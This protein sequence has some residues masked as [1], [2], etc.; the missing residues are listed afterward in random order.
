MA[1]DPVKVSAQGQTAE[2]KVVNDN[3]PAS[4]GT[5]PADQTQD[6]QPITNEQKANLD[7]STSGQTSQALGQIQDPVESN[8]QNNNQ[9]KSKSESDFADNTTVDK[10]TSVVGQH[11]SGNTNTL[12]PKPAYSIPYNLLH[13]YSS[14]TYRITL[15]L[16]TKKD[17]NNLAAS[18]ST[19]EPKYSLISSA[20][21]YSQTAGLPVEVR[22]NG[23]YA[24]V[25]STTRHPDFRTDFFIDNLNLTTVVGLNAKSKAS[26]A[27]EISFNIVEPYGLSLLDRLLSVCETSGDN[28]P[29]YIEQPYLLQVDLL[30]SPSDETL[31]AAKKTNNVIDRKRIAI[32]LLDMKINPTGSGTTYSIR[33]IPYNHVAFSMTTSALPVPLNVEASTV[34]EFFGGAEDI[35]RLF[36][37]TNV[38]E[39]RIESELKLYIDEVTNVGGIPPTPEEIE[40]RR[41]ALKN[42]NIYASKS[43]TAG[44]NNYMESI[45]KSQQLSDA[46]PTRIAFNIPSDEIAKSRI[47]GENSQ[48]S[49]SKM[50]DQKNG[51]GKVEL[52]KGTQ[53]FSVSRGTSVVE[54]IDLVMGKSDYLKNQINTQGKDNNNKAAKAEYSNNNE[55]TEDKEI[56]KELDWYKIV[57]TVAL[58]DYD[59]ARNAFSKTILY[60]ILPYKGA[61]AYHPNFPKISAQALE[62]SVVREYNY[63]YTGKNKDILKLD[64][65]FNSSFF[66]QLT[67]YRSQVARL[68]SNRF[69]NYQSFPTT[70][71][72]YNQASQKINPPVPIYYSGSNDSSNSM[73]TAANP[74]ERVIAD[75]KNSIYSSQRGDMLNIKLQIVGDPAFIKQDDVFYNPGSVNEYNE[76]SKP[77]TRGDQAVPINKDGQILFDTQQIYVKVNVKNAVDI[78]DSKGIVNKQELLKNGRYTNGTFSGVYKVTTVQ[79]SFSRGQFVQTLDLIRMPDMLEDVKTVVGTENATTQLQDASGTDTSNFVGAPK[80]A[81]ANSVAAAQAASNTDRLSAAANQPAVGSLASPQNAN[82]AQDIAPQNTTNWTF[83]DAFAQ[84]RKDFGNKP[85]GIFEWRGKLYQTNYQNEP[86]VANPTPVYPGANQ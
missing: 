68:G 49:D 43:Y 74:D 2:A 51:V 26:N 30:S 73:N 33:A 21:G 12:A 79:S 34:G 48:S 61:N 15:F 47:V 85:G 20:G 5:G 62:A 52:I 86:Y 56:P 1:Y 77:T 25:A 54:V 22:L 13:D 7:K 41:R 57:P 37:N 75:L 27:I 9:I 10:S 4:S 28:N 40:N 39:N 81:L 6:P 83:S 23:K 11:V 3:P 46:P 58:N 45:A 36:T 38:D 66:T 60:S 59:P 80:P 64:I 24:E 29:N 55:R 50:A 82:D 71:Y 18:P 67:T 65:D 69:N 8:A 32:K 31:I 76:Y 63:L 78:D 44:Y 72:S 19:F 17:Y 14:Y 70:E 42:A 16:L 35:A 53:T 84:A